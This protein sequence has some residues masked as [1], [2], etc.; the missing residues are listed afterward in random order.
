MKEKRIN[1][2]EIGNSRGREMRPEERKG[3]ERG[4]K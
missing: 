2:N 1:E 4:K 3:L